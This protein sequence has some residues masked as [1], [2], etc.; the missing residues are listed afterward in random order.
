MNSNSGKSVIHSFSAGMNMDVDKSLL[1]EN[2]YRYAENIRTIT[3]DGSTTGAITNIEGS[4]IISGLNI[5]DEETVIGTATVRDIGLILTVGGGSVSVKRK[6]TMYGSP[7][8]YHYDNGSL[9]VTAT[10]PETTNSIGSGSIQEV[11]ILQPQ[12]QQP[13]GYSYIQT[14]DSG[15]FIDEWLT[16]PDSELF[17]HYQDADGSNS[18][19]IRGVNGSGEFIIPQINHSNLFINTLFP[20]LSDP[21]TAVVY[22]YYTLPERDTTVII[23][24]DKFYE[25]PGDTSKTRLLL[26]DSIHDYISANNVNIY[27]STES[28]YNG[29]YSF[30]YVDDNNII[31]PK[32]YNGTFKDRAFPIDSFSSIDGKAAVTISVNQDYMLSNGML[33]RVSSTDLAYNN[34]TSAI[35]N[36]SPGLWKLSI[37]S[38][39]EE[40]VETPVLNRIY[41]V[42]FNLDGTIDSFTNVLRSEGVDFGIPNGSS[43]SIVTRYEDDDNIKMYWADGLNLIRLINISPSADD[44]NKSIVHPSMFDIVPSAPLK[45]PSIESIGYGRLNSGIIEYYYQLFTKSGSETML[46]QSTPPIILTASNILNESIKYYGT[47]LGDLYGKPSGKSVKVKID[48]PSDSKFT[49]V[50]L[51]SAY[52]YNYSE[53][54]VITIVKQIPIDDSVVGGSIYIE[55]GGVSAIGEL[56]QAEFNMIGGNLFAPKYIESKDNILFAANTNEK[57]FDTLD[58]NGNEIYDTRS[59]QFDENAVTG[60]YKFDGSYRQY[61]SAQ[62]ESI[63]FTHDSIH[64]EIYTNKRYSDLQF[65]YNRNGAYGGSGVN[66]D[67]VFTNTYLIESY[68]NHNGSTPGVGTPSTESDKLIDSRTAR[69]GDVKRLGVSTLIMK[70]SDGSDNVVNL[71]EFSLP[72]HDGPINYSNPYLASTFKSYQR[73]EIYRFAIVLYDEKGR[74][75]PAKWIADI[76]FPAGYIESSSW[77]SSIFE[78]PEEYVDDCYAGTIYE[79]QELLV[80]PLGVKFMFRNLDK[81]N[82]T[83]YAQGVVQKTG[84]FNYGSYILAPH[85]VISMAYNYS[86]RAPWYDNMYSP[87]NIRFKWASD[88]VNDESDFRFH[89]FAP[90]R[91]NR[92]FLLFVNPETSYYGVDFSEQLRNIS[93]SPTIDIVDCIFPVTTNATVG[94]NYDSYFGSGRCNKLKFVSGGVTYPTAMYTAADIHKYNIDIEKNLTNS[95]TFYSAGLAGTVQEI[96]S[97]GSQSYLYNYSAPHG[98]IEGLEIYGSG[99]GQLQHGTKSYISLGGVA[100]NDSNITDYVFKNGFTGDVLSSGQSTP[101]P[102]LNKVLDNKLNA[103]TFKYYN[104]YSSKSRVNNG[105]SLILQNSSLIDGISSVYTKSIDTPSI[106]LNNTPLSYNIYDFEYSG[107]LSNSETLIN[108]S[109]SNYI[110]IGGKQYLN[111]NATHDQVN[112]SNLAWYKN[113][114]IA[115]GQASGQHGDGLVIRLEDDSKFPSIDRI[116]YEKRRYISDPALGNTH[117]VLDEVVSSSLSTFVTNIKL[118]NESIYGGSSIQDRQFTEYISTGSVIDIDSVA[119]QKIVFGGDTFIGIFDYTIN[120]WTDPVVNKEDPYNVD[121]TG[122]IT[123]NNT[124]DE[125]GRGSVLLNQRKYIGALIPLESSINMHLVNSKSYIAS[126]YNP[127]IDPRPGV[128][129]PAITEGG[130]YTF[131]QDYTQYEYNSAYSSEKTALGFL[132]KL[133]TSESDK[134]FDCRVWSSEVKTNDELYDKWSKFKVADYIDVDTQFGEITGIKKFNNKLFFWQKNSFGILSVND[135]SLITDNNISALTLGTGGILSRYDYISTSNG[136]KFGSIG[137]VA[138]SESSLYWYDHDMAEMCSYS[139]QLSPLSKAKG[140]QTLINSNKGNIE[141][142]I[143]MVFDRKYNEIQITLTGLKSATNI[144]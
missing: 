129:G 27:S 4:T 140:I 83:V 100:W 13:E 138:N 96:I 63:P 136:K 77:S 75:S 125:G 78:M 123:P 18:Y 23:H 10:Q 54:P 29:V 8:D 6:G 69:I 127:L 24:I 91:Y 15:A 135:R 64:K 86:I 16:I 115:K 68:G 133:I 130:E 17:V 26:E 61:T 97:G 60:L 7:I 87:N 71:S 32:A 57:S 48:I 126:G 9:E 107:L 22:M 141:N 94:A 119:E 30:T 76:R 79:E 47:G 19:T 124:H 43:I 53:A 110:S 2:Q 65:K 82:K 111:Y 51:I 20:G 118:M 62:I 46:S 1:K 128:Y 84:K 103:I 102:F 44:K 21:Y 45:Q 139:N 58:L 11:F 40:I 70:H 88:M 144:E 12:Y 99:S 95:D 37:D 50:K 80:K 108:T 66:V 35:T 142:N 143:P 112:S 101:A 55:D 109:P 34:V 5:P 42:M 67:Y 93:N 90:A 31:I 56:T 106:Q 131:S 89:E 59:Y 122:Y 85:P 38:I 81:N 121:K 113:T 33:M 120:R 117:R 39:D 73:D 41:R 104:R 52:Y 116:K 105:I 137:N 14:T 3:N 132:S 134:L 72:V 36:V 28:K 74:K 49:E 114:A 98:G 25:V 92:D